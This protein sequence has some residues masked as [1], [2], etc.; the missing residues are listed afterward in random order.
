MYAG[1]AGTCTEK[2]SNRDNHIHL[3]K[4]EFE[5]IDRYLSGEMELFEVREFENRIQ[6]NPALKAQLDEHRTLMR[7]VEE[8]ALQSKMEDFHA[9]LKGSNMD[10]SPA[11][12]KSV[13]M[14]KLVV[15][16]AVA[17]SIALFLALGCWWILQSPQQHERVF[18]AYFK[19]DPGLPSLMSSEGNYDFALAM[20]DYKKGEYQKAIGQWKQQLAAHPASD[21]LHYF[22]GAAYLASDNEAEAIPY[23]EMAV[24]ETESVFRQEAYY[25]LGLAHL[26]MGNIQMAKEA[27]EKSKLEKGEIILNELNE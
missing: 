6:Q 13:F 20:I 25:Y 9:E 17:A 5:I 26:K 14:Q 8:G 24:Q 19:P 2:M 3:S 11:P 22:L 7:A 18:S 12:G 16:I 23:F 4:E 21:T 15:R 10:K 1:I 27:L